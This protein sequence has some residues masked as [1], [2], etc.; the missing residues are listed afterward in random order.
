LRASWRDER[1]FSIIWVAVVFL[2]LIAS[3]ALAIDTSGAFGAARA[4]QNT[5][6]LACL[7]GV[8]ELPDQ[9]AAVDIA[10][11]YIDANWPTMAGS[12]LSLNLPTATYDSG[13]GDS[14]FIDT[15]YDGEDDRMY[16][17]ITQ[18]HENTFARAI[19]QDTTTVVQEAACSFEQVRTGT[20][21]LPI[22]ALTGAWNGDLFDCAAKVTG[23][24]GALDSG[25]G[26]NAYRDAVGNGMVGEFL[27]H[28]GIQSAVDPDTGFAR[29]DCSP[30]GFP[31]PCNVIDA[32]S[33]NMVGPWRQGLTI[34]FSHIAGADCVEAGTFNCDS[35]NQVFGSGLDPLSS[36]SQPAW[37]EISL[38]GSY[39][40]AQAATN[41][42]AKHWFY[43][44]QDMKCDSPR[45]ATVPII[46]WS[47]NNQPLNWDIGGPKGTLPNGKKPVKMI[48]FYTIYIREPNTIADLGSGPMEADVVWFGPDA[49]CDTGELF[50]PTGSTTPVNAGV[51][52]VTP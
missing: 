33:G 3:A 25:S 15:Q 19:G 44:G 18:V 14:V 21:M 51:K 1:G 12:V 22:G 42:N 38:Y 48:G 40:T 49:R 24:C 37:W 13:V 28:H 46:N 10:V 16:L 23:N 4:D 32:E 7:A 43:N 6:D 20:G 41:P 17:R 34:R 36:V 2:F 27:K 5:A 35:I 50:Q 11:A 9:A 47:G 8:A 31:A 29:V 52:L 26:A 39:A 45:L 30:P